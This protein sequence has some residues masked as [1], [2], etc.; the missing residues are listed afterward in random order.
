MAFLPYAADF[1]G[2]KPTFVY[3]R[4]RI[5]RRSEITDS[6]APCTRRFHLAA[7]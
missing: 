3:Y 1:D 2:D 7:R 4:E 5:F 6:R